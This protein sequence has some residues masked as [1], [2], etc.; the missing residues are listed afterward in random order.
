MLK[1][2]RSPAPLCALKHGGRAVARR[3][4]LLL[5]LRLLLRLLLIPSRGGA[6]LRGT[7]DGRVLNDCHTAAAEMGAGDKLGM[8]QREKD[9]KKNLVILFNRVFGL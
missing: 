6:V 4:R 3:H 5:L 2:Q 1:A 7:I 8:E 9:K